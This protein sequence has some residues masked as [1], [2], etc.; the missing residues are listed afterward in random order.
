MAA[1]ADLLVTH[2]CYWLI[3]NRGSQ[4]SLKYLSRSFCDFCQKGLLL[5]ETRSPLLFREMARSSGG[6][7]RET[8]WHCQLFKVYL[9]LFASGHALGA[10]V[11][12][13]FLRHHVWTSWLSGRETH[14]APGRAPRGLCERLHLWSAHGLL[15]PLRPLSIQLPE[16]CAPSFPLEDCNAKLYLHYY[17]HSHALSNS[18]VL[19]MGPEG[20]ANQGKAWRKDKTG[21]ELRHVLIYVVQDICLPYN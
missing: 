19:P 17:H 1:M 9:L 11:P 15:L 21:S 18:L 6:T 14:Q 12:W 4:L 13:P 10:H 8:C 7:L 2:V 5:W 3:N 16:Q 20:P